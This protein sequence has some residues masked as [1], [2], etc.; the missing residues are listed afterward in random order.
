MT[1]EP[2]VIDSCV[3]SSSTDFIYWLKSYHGTK[4]ISS[5]TYAELQYYFIEKK[6]KEPIFFDNLL[7][8]SSIEVKW[9]RKDEALGAALFGVASNSFAKDFRDF[10]IGSHASIAPW[11]VVTNNIKDFYFLN[12]RVKLPEDFKSEHGG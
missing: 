1:L 3:F 7:K 6:K 11:I 9:F 2:V 4:I 10:M 5:I 12:G 8:K